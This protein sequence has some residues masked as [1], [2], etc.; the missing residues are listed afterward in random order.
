MARPTKH[1]LIESV[2]E[3]TYFKPRAIP[4][5]ELEEVILSL[6]ELESLKLKFLGKLEQEKAAKKMN[7][8]RTT[9]WRIYNKAGEKIADALIN[10]KAIKIEG[11]YYKLSKRGKK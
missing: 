10:G 3:S 5:S 6:E 2:P 1:R 4:L 11:G 8:S 9:F 7:V